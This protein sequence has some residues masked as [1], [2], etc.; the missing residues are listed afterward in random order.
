MEADSSLPILDE[1]QMDALAEAGNI[2][3]GASATALS[4]L[5]N[6][7]V[8]ITTPRVTLTSMEEVRANYPVPC[9]VVG[10]NYVKGLTGKNI[11]IVKNEDALLIVGLMMGME[12]PEKPEGLGEMELSAMSEAM[13]QMMGSA[14][15]AMADFLDCTI[16]ISPPEVD[17][18]DI[19]V[20]GLELEDI[21]EDSTI[22]MV[23]FRM[24]IEDVIDSQLL[25]LLPL[26]FAKDMTFQML[27]G[28]NGAVSENG[29]N[30]VALVEDPTAGDSAEEDPEASRELSAMVQELK[31]PK[32]QGQVIT[33]SV[34]PIKK[35]GISKPSFKNYAKLDL[36]RGIPVEVQVVFGKT[37]IPLKHVFTLDAGD[38]INLDGY[39]GEPVE[40]YA[41]KRLVAKG[42]VV[43]VN[44]QFGVKVSEIV[45]I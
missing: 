12:Y 32:P 9:L 43:L 21:K 39:L 8:R 34:D 35:E 13:N 5:V 33:P 2:S 7:K 1:M 28:L 31:E 6:K 10:V 40:L 25:Q 17:L 38:I 42:E 16:D 19:S 29:K 27:L 15:T 3:L 37:K 11:L 4:Q 44:G 20:E 30:G 41:N 24:E 18:V 14:S 23:S 26:Q 45:R 36:I 22:V